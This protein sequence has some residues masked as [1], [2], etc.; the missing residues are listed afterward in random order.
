MDI[1]PELKPC[2]ERINFVERYL[3]M[4]A[5][6]SKDFETR[7]S[8]Y[9]NSTITELISTFGY[10]VKYHKGEN[11][12]KILETYS[13]YQF[14]FNIILKGGIIQFVWDVLRNNVRMDL[15]WGPWGTIVHSISSA[16]CTTKPIFHDYAELK[17]I[18]QEAFAIYEDFK[19][20]LL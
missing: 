19:R 1:N 16:P 4:L 3:N 14:Q 8:S 7:F 20:C 2:L 17:A 18:L 15:A 6:Y 10:E 9:D 12:F 13:H 11:F 5:T